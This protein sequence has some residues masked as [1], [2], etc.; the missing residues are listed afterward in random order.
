M[1]RRLGVRVEHEALLGRAH[2]PRALADL[3]VELAPTEVFA[4]PTV[5][6][7]AARIESRG[8]TNASRNPGSLEAFI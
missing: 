5:R 3:G 8:S 7:L 4:N 6:R 1:L 2:D